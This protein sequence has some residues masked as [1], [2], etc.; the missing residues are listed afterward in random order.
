MGLNM[1]LVVRL[2]AVAALGMATVFT[3]QHASAQYRASVGCSAEKIDSLS[4]AASLEELECKCF[5]RCPQPSPLPTPSP[6]NVFGCEK[7]KLIAWLDNHGV[8]GGQLD[9][10]I[11]D[12]QV[13]WIVGG[14]LS[15]KKRSEI[16]KEEEDFR[17]VYPVQSYITKSSSAAVVGG[18]CVLTQRLDVHKQ[19]SNGKEVFGTF[20]I[21]FGI[22]TNV[23]PPRIVQQYI[24]VLSGR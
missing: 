2:F 20:R 16:A 13:D 15:T 9:P 18:Q 23:D 5:N 22:R 4:E 12:D 7:G 19:R 6:A 3:I 17:K 14:K 10:S 24:D 11:Y 1:C 21:V 8:Y